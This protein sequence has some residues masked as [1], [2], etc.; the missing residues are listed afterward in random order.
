VAGFYISIFRYIRRHASG[1]AKTL[2]LG[3]LLFVLVR[4]LADTEVFDLSLPLWFTLLVS[5]VL[6]E[7][8]AG[9]SGA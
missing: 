8:A 1:A 6:A 5:L 9:R 7:S 4:G 3:F 2:L